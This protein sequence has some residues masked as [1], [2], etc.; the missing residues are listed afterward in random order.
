MRSTMPEYAAAVV[1]MASSASAFAPAA[2]HR[3]PAV[4]RSNVSPVRANGLAK[5][6]MS[7]ASIPANP[8]LGKGF[9]SAA[10][11]LAEFDEWS[12]T[13]PS[14]PHIPPAPRYSS[15]DWMVNILNIFKSGMLRRVS[16]HLLANTIFAILVYS[17]TLQIPA[18]AACSKI[19][20]P[21]GHSLSGAA[22][23][24]LLVFR[25]NSAYARVYDA[26]CIWG[27][28]TNTIREMGRSTHTNMAG[29]DREHALMLTAALPTIM[30]N[31]LQTQDDG[32]RTEAWSPQQKQVLTGLLSEHDFKC[33]W[34][35]RNRPMALCKMIGA[36]YRSWFTNVEQLKKKFGAVNGELTE[37]QRAVMRSNIQT[38][39][40]LMEQQLVIISNCYGACERIVRSNVP[41]SYSRHT[42]RFL[43]V[44]CFTLPFV[45][46]GSL[47][48]LM[49][50]TVALIC[51]GLF[52]IEEVGHA[53]EDPFNVHMFVQ[54][55][56]QEDTLIIEGSQANLREDALDR[57][58]GLQTMV[59]AR[60]RYDGDELDFDVTEFHTEWKKSAERTMS[61]KIG[62]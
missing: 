34:A 21:T 38:E 22:L 41:A 42:S 48:W 37:D 57:N 46:V 28:L 8:G 31:H 49:I 9:V 27:Q 56:G 59:G 50:P 30:L 14:Y 20:G 44:W 32:Y 51:W 60:T 36:V 62:R 13:K 25:T 5:L 45:L 54:G 2:F 7:A 3:T 39:R 18:L 29:L 16:S 12:K 52:I 61:E 24:L 1:L 47:G 4:L 40:A 33:I 55:S 19:L 23:S 17:L 58:P 43:S 35:A 11:P 53:L 15:Q 10:V 26:R 6:S